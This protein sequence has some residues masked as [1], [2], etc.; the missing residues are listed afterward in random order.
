MHPGPQW[1]ESY[2][3]G[4]LQP[5]TGHLLYSLPLVIFCS[6][7]TPHPCHTP[8][9]FTVPSSSPAASVVLCDAYVYCVCN[10][11]SASYCDSYSPSAST[12]SLQL[13][14]SLRLTQAS[15]PGMLSLEV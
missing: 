4:D 11:W 8:S 7:R 6:A 9:T 3:S 14:T 5:T 13:F 1:T 10:A 2:A 12:R 15:W